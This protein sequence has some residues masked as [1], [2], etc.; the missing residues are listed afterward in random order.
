MWKQIA[1]EE[2][3]R[4]LSSHEDVELV[5]RVIAPNHG[6]ER[7]CRVCGKVSMT[8]DAYLLYEGEY[9]IRRDVTYPEWTKIGPPRWNTEAHW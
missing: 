5:N 8:Y 2:F 1:K 7:V 6:P 3:D 4:I 9:F